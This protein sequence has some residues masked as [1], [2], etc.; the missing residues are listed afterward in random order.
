MEEYPVRAP[1]PFAERIAGH[2]VGFKS[3]LF[4]HK[5][6]VGLR[7]NR[8]ECGKRD[9]IER[10]LRQVYWKV[11]RTGAPGLPRKQIE[12][13]TLGIKT[14]TFRHLVNVFHKR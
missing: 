11:N 10:Y 5:I 12:G 6:A 9:Q 13:N 2:T 3:S 8:S 14:S 4:R 7:P 1:E